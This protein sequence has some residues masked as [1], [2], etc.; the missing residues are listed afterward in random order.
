MFVH[1]AQPVHAF[2]TSEEVVKPK[3]TIC[4]T[5][6]R[7]RDCEGFGI[8][9]F[10]AIVTEGR[11]NNATAHVYL[12]DFSNA[13]VFEIDRSKGLAPTA[14]DRFFS[15]GYFVM[16]DDSQLPAELSSELGMDR[17]V[18]LSQGRYPIAESNGLIRYVVPFR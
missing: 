4:F 6:A 7:K 12:D 5:I 2:S 1:A 18:T 10:H 14:Y 15:S 17:V 9:N 11:Y 8:C 13:L 3:V 16:E